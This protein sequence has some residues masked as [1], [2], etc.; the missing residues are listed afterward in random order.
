MLN[1]LQLFVLTGLLSLVAM[2]VLGMEASVGGETGRRGDADKTLVEKSPSPDA[3]L[4]DTPS[5]KRSGAYAKR[6]P[7]GNPLGLFPQSPSQ[8]LS[9]DLLAQNNVTRVTGVETIQTE[10]GLELI[11]RTVTGSERLVPLILPQG[12]DLVID[13]LDATLAFSIR[14]GVTETNPTS[15]ISRITVNKVDDTSIRVTITG[16]NQTPSAEIVPG[17]DDLVLSVTPQDTTAESEPIEEIEVIAT[18]EAEEDGYRVDNATTATRTDTPLR[19]IPQSIQV[20]PQQVIEDQNITRIGEALRNVSGVTLQRDRSNASDRFVIRGFEDSRI[21]RNGFRT[22]SSLGGT[23]STATS[24]VER[25]EVLK[26]PASVLYGQVEPGGIVNLVTKKPQAEAVF[27]LE[28]RAGSFGFIEPSLDF[29]GPL[30]EDEK[31]TYRFN[32]SYQSDGRFQDFADID[33]LSISPVIRY[34]FSDATSLTFEYSFLD[35]EQTYDD[36][37]P[38][39]PVVFD[40]PKERFLGEPDDVYESTTNSFFLTLDH[41]FNDSIR[42]RSG[43]TAELADLEETAFRPTPGSFD[44]ETNELNRQFVDREFARDNLSW[45][46]DL[47]SEFNTGSVEH[48]LL[49]GFELARSDAPESR[50]DVFDPDDRPFTIDVLDPQY[51]TPIP[52]SDSRNSVGDFDTTERILGLYLQ[53]LITILPNLKL[54]VGGRYDFAGFEEEFE[55]TFAGELLSSS[56][57]FDTEAFSPRVGFVYQPI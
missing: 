43:F 34:E 10:A 46:T 40:L 44:P 56:T 25:V 23:I 7:L 22:G 2:P 51:D 21:L 19:D 49:A 11:L 24:T 35:L 12:N 16:T 4:K 18:G 39:D 45:Q 20:V 17:R 42:V 33:I 53:D 14:N 48:Q 9:I 28:F 54:L 1:R 5:D 41:R 47:I 3:V 27:N 37:L 38:I 32:A 57:D 52:S 15:G 8:P 55:I 13:I 50:A 26:G 31:L 29:T 36:G 6:Y 30:T